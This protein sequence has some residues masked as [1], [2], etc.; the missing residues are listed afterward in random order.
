MKRINI[1]FVVALAALLSLTAMPAGAIGPHTIT[2][3]EG[4]FPSEGILV[5]V[6]VYTGI[7][8]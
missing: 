3:T 1:L 5:R 8:N 2:L 7:N 6:W 4:G